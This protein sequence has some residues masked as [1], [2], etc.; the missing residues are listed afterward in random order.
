M[1]RFITAQTAARAAALAALAAA[2]LAS[3][4]ARATRPPTIYD[5]HH[6]YPIGSRAAGMGGAYTAL[7]CD[8]AALHYNPGAL[9]CAGLSRLELSANAYMIQRFSLPDAYGE[10]Q[11]IAATTYHSIPS[12][13][14]GVRILADGDHATGVGRWVFG[15]SV[16]VPQSLA[17][18]VR[19]V[20][21]RTPNF[22]SSSVRDNLTVGEIGLGYQVN[23]WLG[24]GLSVGAALRTMESTQHE[25]LVAIREEGGQT[26]VDFDH[27]V[28]EE[29]LLAVGVRAK[30]GAR[31]T[32]IPRL[33]FGLTLTSPTLHVYGTYQQSITESY[34]I[35][36]EIDAIPDRYRASSEV[37]L[38]MRVAVGAAYTSP[39]FTASLD[40]SMNLPRD[41]RTAY[42]L[43]AIEVEGILPAEGL[44]E[45]VLHRDLQPNLNLGVEIAL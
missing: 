16:S 25:L 36:P 22:V 34:A 24:V 15:L 35:G 1:A 43:E 27:F 44:T 33:S 26:Y 29:E 42:D 10:G 20:D 6:Q 41:I 28:N 32:P 39:G 14:G 18:K 7:A 3:G 31:I 21:P 23:R 11:D 13:V 30:L 37:A 19:P 45:D 5:N 8:E 40:L 2:V 12:I 9:A 4:D 38:P 17:L